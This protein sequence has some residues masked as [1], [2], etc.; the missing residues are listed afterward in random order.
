MMCCLEHFENAKGRDVIQRK[1]TTW[2]PIKVVSIDVIAL[3]VIGL[4]CS[5]ESP[6]GAYLDQLSPIQFF[7]TCFSKIQFHLIV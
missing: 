4:S 7:T 5:H 2:I 6:N 1:E 3:S